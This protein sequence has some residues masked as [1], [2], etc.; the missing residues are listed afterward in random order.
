[1]EKEAKQK[2]KKRSLGMTM[3]KSVRCLKAMGGDPDEFE[4]NSWEG[5]M[6]MLSDVL[7][8]GTA[9][10]RAAAIMAASAWVWAYMECE[11]RKEIAELGEIMGGETAAKP[12]AA[13]LAK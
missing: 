13:M 9:D 6:T 4:P 12:A 7:R 11:I 8:R 10:D 1:M 2:L 5:V 3:E